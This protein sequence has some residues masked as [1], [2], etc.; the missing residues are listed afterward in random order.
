MEPKLRA[1]NP[2]LFLK[3][4]E[5]LKEFNSTAPK[6]LDQNFAVAIAV[7]IHRKR[8]GP[9]SATSPPRL[10]ARPDS[11]SPVSNHI[12]EIEI[13]DRSYEK[14]DEFLP[15]KGA[16]PIYKPFTLSFKNRSSSKYNNWRNS[17]ALQGGLGCDAPY[18]PDYLQS[19]VYLDEPR[20]DCNFRDPV[21]GRC[22]SPAGYANTSQICF[23]PSK[24][25]KP[26]GPESMAQYRPKLLSRGIAE[27]SKGYWCIEPTVNVLMDLLASPEK[28]VPLYPFIVALYGGSPYF[29]QWSDEVS[30]SRFEADIGLNH[31]CFSALFDPSQDSSLNAQ[32]ISGKVKKSKRPTTS[33]ALPRS[34]PKRPSL[35][36]PI[37]Y[38]KRAEKELVIQ[39][40]ALSDPIQ[41]ARMLERA[42]RGHKRALDALAGVLNAR[43]KF[44]LVEQLDGFDLLATSDD[45]ALLFEV[46]TWTSAN[47][48]SQVRHG[49]AQLREYRYRNRRELPETVELYLVLDRRPPTDSWAWEFLVKDCDVVPAWIDKSRI[50]TFA[51]LRDLLP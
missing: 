43:G 12:L 1:D 49:W 19:S 22:S 20:F 2:Q 31:V 34:T 24:R 48:A 15:K 28:R 25:G 6:L 13:C 38:R 11:G 36:K 23:N 10:L 37:P 41:R 21:T 35:S 50:S 46:K 33:A 14:Y 4:V 32:L 18:T 8:S 40:E 5:L 47:L 51:D 9:K 27:D 26:P 17:F 42:R 45:A 3:G 44:K 39:A 7:L 16:G 29:A 30:R